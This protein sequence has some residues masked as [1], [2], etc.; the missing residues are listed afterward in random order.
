MAGVN[1][2]SLYRGLTASALA[3][4]SL[5]AM[6]A[7]AAAQGQPETQR[8]GTV[9]LDEIVVQSA[10]TGGQAP[11]TGTVGQPPAP[12]AGG[13]VGSGARL[14]ILGNRSFMDTP[15]N[16]TGYTDKL[17]QDQQARSV[18]DIALNDPSVR[19]DAP[20]FSERDSFLIRGFPVVNLD[21]FYDGLPYIAN[22]RRHFLEGIERVEILKGPSQLV[23]GGL[24]RV[25]GTINLVP[26]RATDDPLTRLT[27][28]FR[29]DGQLWTHLDAGRRFGPTGEWGIRFNGSYRDGDTAFDHNEQ[30]VGVAALGLD[31]R[32][33][34]FRASLDLNHSTQNLDG[35]TSL[36]NAAAPGFDIPDAPNGRINAANPWEYHDSEYN[37]ATGRV[38]F[39]ILPNTTVYAAA[40]ASR[41]REDFLTS[42]YTIQNEDGDA[43]AA[44][45]YNP[46]E[47]IGFAGEVGLRSEFDTG[48][49]SHQL[50]LS[51]ARATN[52]NN[53]GRFNFR[54][55]VGP[56]YPTN[57][58]DPVFVP[59]STV[60]ID[61][62]PRSDDLIPFADVLLTSY[63]ISDTL[64]FLDDRIQLTV[65]G[66]YQEI[67]S[68]GF[69]TVPPGTTPPGPPP[70]PVGT[71]TFFYEEGR[72]SP[73][74]AALVWVTDSFSVYANYVEALTEG[75]IAP[76]GT[77][78]AGEVFSPTVN[79]QK[80][81][82]FK[83]DLGSFALTASL[84]EIKQAS[85]IAG[86]A[87]PGVLPSFSVDGLQV[88]RGIEFTVFGEPLQGLRLLGGITLIDAELRNVAIDRFGSDNNGNRAPGVPEV[89][90]SLYGEYDLPWVAG[91]TATGRVVYNGS[92]FY[93]QRNLQEVDDWTRVDVGLRYALEG[94]FDK[95]M[96]LRAGIENVFDENYWASSARGF[97]AAGAPRTFTLSASMEF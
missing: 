83:Y 10:G 23:N 64:S 29:S 15:F 75:A 92:T 80:E 82:G 24:G 90:V 28:G 79:E 33:D 36:F 63:G 78:N 81:V 12:Y 34:R 70:P 77:I 74:I 31:Y 86:T 26:K 95:P 88:N 73:A 9:V 53:R 71:R 39:D 46:Q 3:G 50:N 69:N 42:S 97:L 56:G 57:I 96:V 59:E 21:I 44:F 18:G 1:F 55:P 43:L 94:P 62:L 76:A 60:N 68:R 85:G 87:P 66:R 89:A 4:V 41:Y 7:A 38:E 32:G 16:I 45:G 20:P 25:G 11:P 67:R 6:A 5:L 51:A 22:P 13:Q 27:L 37:M 17:I 35:P 19:A 48:F 54:A 84:F 65:G 61:G 93:D 72:F 47:I 8:D 40:G 2:G 49:V 91:L 52:E 58:Y 14:G 30:E